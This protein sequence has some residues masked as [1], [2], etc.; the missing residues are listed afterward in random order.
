MTDFALRRGGISAAGL[1]GPLVLG[2]LALV[3][4]LIY[5]GTQD[6]LLPSGAVTAIYA[7]FALLGVALARAKDRSLALASATPSRAKSA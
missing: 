7:L 6:S 4:L 2:G 5:F 1:G 3:G